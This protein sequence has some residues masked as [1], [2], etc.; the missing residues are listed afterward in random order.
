[1]YIYIIYIYVVILLNNNRILYLQ[2]FEGTTQI[3][4]Y[5]IDHHRMD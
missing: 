4:I 3:Y 2:K 5:I 1:M